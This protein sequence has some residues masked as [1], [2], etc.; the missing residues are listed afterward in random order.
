M[1]KLWHKTTNLLQQPSTPCFVWEEDPMTYRRK[2]MNNCGNNYCKNKE[3]S[4][5]ESQAFLRHFSTWKESCGFWNVVFQLLLSRQTL[6]IWNRTKQI[7]INL[8]I[9]GTEER[10][11][12]TCP[13]VILGRLGVSRPRQDTKKESTTSQR[14]DR[15]NTGCGTGSH[16]GNR[17]WRYPVY[18][19]VV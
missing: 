17:K 3:N 4:Y 14:Q 7:I 1:I 18:S 9:P 16:T 11:P 10:N 6:K 12:S 15:L 2:D 5:K 19:N 8:I 13:P